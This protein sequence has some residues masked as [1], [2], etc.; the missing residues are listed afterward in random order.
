MAPDAR[1][2]P[3][4]ED[5]TTGSTTLLEILEDLRSVGYATQ[6]IAEEGGMVRCASCSA[7]H[8]ASELEPHGYRRTEGASDAADMNLVIWGACESCGAG[9][10]L[11]LGY[12]PNA[13]AADESVLEHL[14]LDHTA[15]PGATPTEKA[16]ES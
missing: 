9:A 7:T 14:E 4:E 10:V 2:Q 15:V 8:A 3:T 6:S 5:P 11:I 13:S 12:G 1:I 16:A